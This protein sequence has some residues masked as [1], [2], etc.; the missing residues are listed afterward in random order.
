MLQT[1]PKEKR[2]SSDVAK[3]IAY[4]DRLFRRRWALTVFTDRPIWLA[5]RAVL[6]PCRR[7]CSAFNFSLGVMVRSP[8]EYSRWESVN[9]GDKYKKPAE[10]I[11]SMIALRAFLRELVGYRIFFA[12]FRKTNKC[13][14]IK[15]KMQYRM[16][17][18][19]DRPIKQH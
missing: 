8:F 2:E 17:P 14:Y 11:K 13:L 6:R 4:C 12:C 19:K 1:L 16:E 3:G 9:Q 10:H 15:W 7:S 18:H 5:I